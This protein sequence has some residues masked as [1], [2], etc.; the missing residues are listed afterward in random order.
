[1]LRE[2]INAVREKGPT[3]LD[4]YDSMV[5]S[6]IV[7]LSGISIQ[8]NRPVSFPDFT[9]GKWETRKPYFAI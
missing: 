6:A 7:E 2:F 9:R 4:I 8:K 1:M 5:M 3:P